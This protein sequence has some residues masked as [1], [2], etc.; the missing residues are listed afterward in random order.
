MK[1]IKKSFNKYLKYIVQYCVLL[2]CFLCI[3]AICVGC[4][5]YDPFTVLEYVK[6]CS[7]D[8]ECGV[9]LSFY[10]TK[11]SLLYGYIEYNNKKCEIVFDSR[12]YQ[13]LHY[14]ATFRI[15][16]VSRYG[17]RMYE[18]ANSYGEESNYV[19]GNYVVLKNDVV[20]LRVKEDYL[21]DGELVGKELSISPTSIT[22]VDY[23]IELDLS[24]MWKNSSKSMFLTTYIDAKNF[25]LGTYKD[26]EV[27]AIWEKDDK[28]KMYEIIDGVQQ[29]DVI[30]YGSYIYTGEMVALHF[31]ENGISDSEEIVLNSCR[32]FIYEVPELYPTTDS[33]DIEDS[34]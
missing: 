28:F 4:N 1:S 27:M 33:V 19:Y 26:R 6:W 29:L 30:C 31:E 24:V 18:Y 12:D 16:L 13:G 21:F 10:N 23:G 17:E 22:Y 3:S 34:V 2:L 25:S 5:K 15:G 20:K 9:Q 8:N 11:H 14:V 7:E 32:D